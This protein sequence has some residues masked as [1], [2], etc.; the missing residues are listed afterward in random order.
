MRES[1]ETP[2]K[3]TSGPEGGGRPRARATN[4]AVSSVGN[5]GF[6]RG[7]HPFLQAPAPPAG[8]DAANGMD[9][10]VQEVHEAGQSGAVGRD[11]GRDEEGEDPDLAV[12][13]D[14]SEA[15]PRVEALDLVEVELFALSPGV[16][17][18]QGEEGEDGARSPPRR[19][20]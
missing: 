19:S 14:V 8:D 1:V 10:R 5:G 7:E 11:D 3:A 20:S 2:S 18:E 4:R 6:R 13:G 12:D 16:E 9:R 15:R 17:I